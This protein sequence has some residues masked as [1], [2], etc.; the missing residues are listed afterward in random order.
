MV[1]TKRRDIQKQLFTGV[2]AAVCRCFTKQVFLKSSH[3]S[4]ETPMLEPLFNKH[5]HKEIPTQMFSCKY[6]KIFKYSFFIQ[7]LR[8]LLLQVLQKKDVPKNFAN[9]NRI[10]RYR[11]PFSSSC[12]PIIWN[13]VKIEGPVQ[14]F[15]SE[16]C[17]IPQNN[18]M[19]N[20]KQ[21]L[22]DVKRCCGK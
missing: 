13:L 3:Y 21:L 6:C 16:F 18:F 22:L 11:R 2:V 4:H 19:H 5:C 8:W 15:C 10:Y 17:E 12:R 7:H 14:A 1:S 20:F 9:S